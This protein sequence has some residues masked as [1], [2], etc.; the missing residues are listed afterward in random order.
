[1]YTVFL[2]YWH[3]QSSHIYHD[4]VLLYDSSCVNERIKQLQ[5]PALAIDKEG[6]SLSFSIPREHDSWE[7]FENGVPLKRTSQITVFENNKWLW[8]GFIT[9]YNKD[10]L[11]NYKINCIGAL[12][13]LKNTVFPLE[14]II[15]VSKN[16]RETM[17]SFG[18]RALSLFM[19]K[20]VTQHNNRINDLS[21]IGYSSRSILEH[22]KIYFDRRLAYSIDLSDDIAFPD[23]FSRIVNF[24]SCYDALQK[25]IVDDFGGF[26]YLRR[27]TVNIDAEIA[28]QD[29]LLSQ[30]GTAYLLLLCYK[31]RSEIITDHIAYLG[32][33]LLDYNISEDFDLATAAIPLG[34]TY[35]ENHPGESRWWLKDERSVFYNIT[36]RAN[37][38]WRQRQ[39]TTHP[40]YPTGGSRIFLPLVSSG[41]SEVVSKY[42]MR[43]V[44]LEFDTVVAKYPDVP[45][46]V[47]DGRQYVIGQIV[48]YRPTGSAVYKQ[49][50]VK[51]NH[52]STSALTPTAATN[53][54]SEQSS[55]YTPWGYYMHVRGLS[56]KKWKNKKDYL[57]E[58]WNDDKTIK[59]F[60]VRQS[61]PGSGGG[62][63]SDGEY[64]DEYM[65]A[66]RI[67]TE[68]YLTDQQFNKLVLDIS[69][70][71][72]SSSENGESLDVR[73]VLG[74]RLPV[75]SS[76]FGDNA[77]PYEIGSIS[78]QLND[79]SQSRLTL[80]GE[81]TKITKLINTK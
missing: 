75:S 18:K 76:L 29:N 38:A 62:G 30:G 56:E 58:T 35:D 6:G 21:S 80:G 50:Y 36:Q 46:W 5:S 49:Y 34:D 45:V 22:Q 28:S 10:L 8:E 52:T 14:N 13:Y 43:D 70:S 67:L 41:A 73:S 20:I 74:Q 64:I 53:Y 48:K 37:Y 40:Y 25:R 9:D 1:M 78:V 4:N 11:G 24:E 54:F 32:N 71:K 77:K 7:M 31:E 2:D 33:D 68:D 42:G 27:A 72:I 69:I 65:Y 61:V 26:F 81:D 60:D 23:H 12:Q 79:D 44:I 19:K 63:S 51:A 66:L 3:E 47:G 15:N 39:I 57:G 17:V 59:L 55:E 16:D